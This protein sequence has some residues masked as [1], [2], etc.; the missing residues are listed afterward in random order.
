MLAFGTVASCAW[1]PIAPRAIGRCPGPLVPSDEITG[2]FVLEHRLRVIAEGVDFPL[3]SVLQKQHD[4]LVFIGL[5]PLGAKLF[6]VRQQGRE[7]KVEAL[8]AAVLPI[9]PLNLLRDM[10]RVLFLGASA[11]SESVAGTQTVVEF[12]QRDGR[13]HA[14]VRHAA[15]AYTLEVDL[16]ERRSLP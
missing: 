1:L 5:S 9:P 15:C 14:I 6:T 8:P 16:V 2:N 11:P 10:H 13:T 12:S 3:Q 7:T 4:E